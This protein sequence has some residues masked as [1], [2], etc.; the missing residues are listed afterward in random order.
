MPW[1][2][3]VVVLRWTKCAI[4]YFSSD[5]LKTFLKYAYENIGQHLEFS[6]LPRSITSPFRCL[7][8][9]KNIQTWTLKN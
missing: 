9:S 1:F 7:K 6:K 2:L 4:F 5:T 3:E 8:V